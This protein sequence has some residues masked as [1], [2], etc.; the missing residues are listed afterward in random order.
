MIISLKA[1][2][3]VAQAV[4]MPKLSAVLGLLTL[5][6]LGIAPLP[7]QAGG[8]RVSGDSAVVQTSEQRAVVTGNGNFVDQNSTQTNID[9]RG[10]GVG[11]QGVV[12]D[13]LQN[14]DVYGHHNQVRQ[15]NRQTT[16]EADTTRFAPR[17]RPH[18]QKKH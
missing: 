9:R 15:S 8:Y 3:T 7:A 16:V 2:Q 18:Y 10:G 1:Y 6:T 17:P 13:Q 4:K 12:Q 14:A 11:N 5:A